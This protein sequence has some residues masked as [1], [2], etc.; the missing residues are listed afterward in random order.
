ME[1]PDDGLELGTALIYTTVNF[2]HKFR[3]VSVTLRAG[4][5]LTGRRGRGRHTLSIEKQT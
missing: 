4:D 2:T 3:N 5:W 1:Q